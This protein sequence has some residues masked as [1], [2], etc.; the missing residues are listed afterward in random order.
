MT[1]KFRDPLS[2]RACVLVCMIYLIFALEI[3]LCQVKEN[4]W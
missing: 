2:A 4:E 1:V 3:S